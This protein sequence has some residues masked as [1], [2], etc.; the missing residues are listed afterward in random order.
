[1]A[2]VFVNV[3]LPGSGL[4]LR[5]HLLSGCTLLL[6]AL[7]MLTIGIS[8][9]FFAG[10]EFAHTLRLMAGVGYA[11]AGAWAALLWWLWQRSTPVSPAQAALVHSQVCRAWLG[12]D[13][14]GARQAA[15]DLC[16]RARH[17]APAWDLLA[18]VGSAE[19]QLSAQR[20]AQRLRSR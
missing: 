13:D 6:I 14:A 18:L 17:Y 11:L 8:A 16:R 7:A 5:D 9:G 19:Q 10:P 15:L 4:I 2:V 1:M 3:V 12:G 20:Q